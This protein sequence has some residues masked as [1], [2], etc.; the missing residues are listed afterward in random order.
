MLTKSVFVS[1]DGGVWRL[2]LQMTLFLPFQ[3]AFPLRFPRPLTLS[4]QKAFQSLVPRHFVSL[5]I[6]S[7]RLQLDAHNISLPYLA[8][9]TMQSRG[10]GYCPWIENALVPVQSSCEASALF[11]TLP[12]IQPNVPILRLFF[13]MSIQVIL[14]WRRHLFLDNKTLTFSISKP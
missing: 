6:E 10:L 1:H 7:L 11:L 2:D 8:I 5:R 3:V 14:R 9:S 13:L 12:R 4:T